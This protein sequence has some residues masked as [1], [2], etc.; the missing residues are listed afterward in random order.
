VSPPNLTWTLD[1]LPGFER[2]VLPMPRAWDGEVD[3][4]LVRRAGGEVPTGAA[5]LYVHGFGDYFF[6][7]HLAE[8]YEEQG[9]AFYAIDLRRHGRALHEGQH[10]NTTRSIDEYVADIDRAVDVLRT[11]EGVRWLLVNGHSTGGLAAVIHASRGARKAD[12]DALFL[13]S[14]FLDMNLPGWQETVLEPVLS[15][16][17][18]FF[19]DVEL[20]SLDAKYGESIHSTARGAW[21]FDLAWKPLAGFPAK[22]G[23]FRAIHLA[24]KEVERGLDIRVPVLLLHAA[25]SS[26]PKQWG[27]DVLTSDIVLDVAD[28]DR[29]APRLGSDVTVVAI[30]D[31]IHDLVL[32][33][34]EARRR[35]FELLA[36]WLR[37][38]RRVPAA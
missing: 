37:K 38:V 20:P 27:E 15:V 36:E 2:T 16:V 8:F 24:Q 17:G 18:R 14:P 25:R 11:Q 23:W 34:D 1:V 4:V 29:L 5:V 3:A 33:G 32:S 12:V 10:P 26:R 30:P 35:T 22:A 21:D 6:Q 13:N 7:S 19:P 9:I 28:M 31:G